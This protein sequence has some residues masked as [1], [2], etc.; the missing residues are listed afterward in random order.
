MNITIFG[1]GYVG[2]TTAACLA[3]DGHTV[4]GVDINPSKVA[5][6]QNGQSP[7]V[8]A[9][10]DELIKEGIET[11][12]LQATVD[13]QTAVSQSDISL[14]CVGTPS[15]NNGSLD[16][17]YIKKV[18]QEIGTTLKK[19]DKYH[20][21]VL[22]STALPGTVCQQLIPL[23]EEYSQKQAG[24]DFGVCMNPE[25]MREGSAIKDYYHPSQIVIGELDQRSGALLEQMYAAVDAPIVHTTIEV[26]ETVKY[27]SNTFHA[28]K[29]A[30]ANEIGNFCK[31]NNVD[32]REVMSIFAQDTQLNISAAYLKPGYAFGGSCLPKDLRALSYRAKEKDLDMPV[33]NAVMQS[34]QQQI[35]RGIQMVEQTKRKKIGVLGLSFKAGTDD[36]RE[37]P[38]VP[39][40]ETL[41]GRG[42]E[43]AVYDEKIELARLIGTNKQFLETE[44]PH[45]ASLLCSSLEE[46]VQ[47]SEVLVVT[48][49]GTKFKN[50]SKLM[51][52]EQIL[53][54]FVDITESN[55]GKGEMEGLYEGICW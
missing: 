1:L 33:L 39:L 16:Y 29:V 9:R 12:R 55:N 2:C 44:I 52:K 24:I 47:R 45:I 50:V 40:I 41:V 4:I 13:G 18:G 49:P 11:G 36:V 20:V 17:Q 43:V 7:I 28:L 51:S 38:A 3:H 54:D 42:Y 23:L 8:E 22:R 53:L 5:Q 6:I 10:L 35:D 31:I 46:L 14:I 30:F 19:I 48:N 27:V 21:I 15:N 26:A 34:N 37:S 25:F 32:G